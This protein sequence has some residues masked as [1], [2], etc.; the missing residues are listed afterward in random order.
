MCH[1]VPEVWESD[2]LAFFGALGLYLDALRGFLGLILT[3]SVSTW[4]FLLIFATSGVNLYRFFVVF[5]AHLYTSGPCGLAAKT[6]VFSISRLNPSWGALRTLLG[7]SGALF[8]MVLGLS[9]APLGRSWGS[10]GLCWGALG[11]LLCALGAVLGRSLAHLVALVR[12]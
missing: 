3:L 6:E 4:R 10:L 7:A 12:F 2:L 11:A 9:W 8:W 1:P 5:V